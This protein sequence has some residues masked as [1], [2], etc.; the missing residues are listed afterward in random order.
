[1]NFFVFS[2]RFAHKHKGIL[3]NI[4]KLLPDERYSKINLYSGRF[5][6]K[7]FSNTEGISH[8]TSR[9]TIVVKCT[10]CYISRTIQCESFK[11]ALYAV[12]IFGIIG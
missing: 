6:N 8:I 1:M 11:L 2:L 9:F 4:C 5:F 12:S 3:S 7:R 10:Y